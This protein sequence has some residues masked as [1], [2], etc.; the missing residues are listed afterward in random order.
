MGWVTLYI[1]GKEDF[2]ED[3][4]EK[5]ENSSLKLMPGYTGGAQAGNQYHDMYWVDETV[6]L[7]DLKEAIGSKLVW[8]YRLQFY[9]S[10]E[11]F[12]ESQ[13]PTKNNAEFTAEERAL[14]AEIKSTYT[15]ESKPVYK[16]A[17]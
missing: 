1:T 11:A 12:V 17:S 8:K 5:L 2:R 4:G 9:T 10:L 15:P 14:L 16:R 7:R 13:N 6:K 3:V